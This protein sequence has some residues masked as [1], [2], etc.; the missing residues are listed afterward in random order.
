MEVI[1]SSECFVFPSFFFFFFVLETVLDT[2]PTHF[3]L[4]ED[5][6]HSFFIILSPLFSIFGIGI[7]YQTKFPQVSDMVPDLKEF[8]NN[9]ATLLAFKS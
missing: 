4:L 6:Y 3:N 1:A 8:I 5:V 9:G 7:N 2:G